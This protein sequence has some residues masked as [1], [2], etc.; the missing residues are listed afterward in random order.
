MAQQIAYCCKCGCV[1]VTEAERGKEISEHQ[2]FYKRAEEMAWQV[3][4]MA[5][6]VS[7]PT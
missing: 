1:T 2:G 7:T 4:A 6:H 3:T 5:A